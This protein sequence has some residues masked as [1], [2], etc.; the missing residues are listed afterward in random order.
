MNADGTV[1]KSF[2]VRDGTLDSQDFNR[3]ISSL[4]IAPDNRVLAGGMFV[5]FDRAPKNGLVRLHNDPPVRFLGFSG[6]RPAPLR[7]STT[8]LHGRIYILERS[9]DLRTW[10]P[11]RTNTAQS[12]LMEI[13]DTAVPS[14]AQHFY[15]II[16]KEP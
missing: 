10:L 16:Q 11:V 2:D 15:R 4:I 14:A 7:I 3:P 5:T 9:D 12:F 6:S 13:Q 1:D 8:A